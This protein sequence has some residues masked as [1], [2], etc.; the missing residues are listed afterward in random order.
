MTKIECFK[1][2]VDV[3]NRFGGV[4]VIVFFPRVTIPG[5]PPKTRDSSA[6]PKKPGIEKPGI[7]SRGAG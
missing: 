2:I 7:E 3:T 6:D 4:C 5:F 1:K